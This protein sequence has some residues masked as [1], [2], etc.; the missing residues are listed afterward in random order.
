MNMETKKGLTIM[1]FESGSILIN[2]FVNGDQLVKAHS[3]LVDTL[4]SCIHDIITPQLQ[5]TNPKKRS[6]ASAF[7][8]TKY[9]E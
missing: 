1:V 2:A 6:R 5:K 7:D 4:S 8:Y 3:F 9:I